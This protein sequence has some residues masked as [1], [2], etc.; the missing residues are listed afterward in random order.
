MAMSPPGHSTG[1]A[2][3]RDRVQAL[4]EP[5]QAER[6]EQQPTPCLMRFSGTRESGRCT[7]ITHH[8]HD[9]ER[10]RGADHGRRRLAGARAESDD[11]E[12]DLETLEQHALEADREGVPVEAEALLAGARRAASASSAKASSS[13][14]SA[15]KPVL[16]R[17]AL[18]SHCNPKGEQ[19]HADDQTAATRGDVL[20]EAR[21]DRDHEHERADEALAAPHKAGAP[22]A[23]DAEREDDRERLHEL[24][25]RREE[26]RGCGADAGD[27][28]G[29][30]LRG[31]SAAP[32][33][34]G[35]CVST[36]A[37]TSPRRSGRRTR[38]SPA[39]K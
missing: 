8:E 26:G 19:Q 10:R 27:V 36:V 16:R 20:R 4:D 12:D 39:R 11:D 31:L 15:L 14:W 33:A 2:V 17:I 1:W 9:H 37:G 35:S 22:A 38:N 30:R 25:A 23:R 3:G 29:A 6:R 24:D 28:H 5:E 34:S 21:A 13:S 32:R 7:A 18:R